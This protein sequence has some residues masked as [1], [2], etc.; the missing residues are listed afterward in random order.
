MTYGHLQADCLYTGISSGP[1]ARYRVWEA[2]TFIFVGSRDRPS[3]RTSTKRFFP[4]FDL[5]RCVGKPRPHM[6]T[7][8]TSTRYKVKVKVKVKV[9]EL[10]KFRKSHFSRSISSATFAR[11]SKLMADVHSMGPVLQRV[12]AR[13]WNFLL[14]NLSQQFKLRQISILHDIQ[15]VI[16]RQCMR[17]QSYGW[18]RW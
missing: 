8:M 17:L 14:G 12:G 1:N 9:T 4:D 2:F 3:V 6:R 18:A 10:V 16:F 7:S 11:S 15:M 5:I 13:F